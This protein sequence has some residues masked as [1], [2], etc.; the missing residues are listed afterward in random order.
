MKS[1]D[2][3]LS[4]A[5]FR[6]GSSIFYRQVGTSNFPVITHFGGDCGSEAEKCGFVWEDRRD[7]GASL[8]FLVESLEAVGRAEALGIEPN[9][10]RPTTFSDVS[11]LIP[12]S[13][14]I[15]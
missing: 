3:F 12:A 10:D 5:V 15:C 11:Y 8:D 14:L 4:F 6:S 2:T 7:T 9:V 1:S 13:F